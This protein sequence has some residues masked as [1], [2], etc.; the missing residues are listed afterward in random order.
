MRNN[1]SEMNKQVFAV[2]VL[3]RFVTEESFGS[4]GGMNVEYIAR[5]SVSRF[6]SSQLNSLAGQFISGFDLNMDLESSED[7]TTGGK[8]N[9]TDLNVSVSKSLF[10]DRLSVSVGNDFLLEGGQNAGGRSS[11]IPGNFSADY[12]LTEDGRYILR[13]YRR[14]ELQNLIDGY[15]V[16]TGLGFR[17]SLQ[18]NRFRYLFMSNA[19]RRER[20]RQ[21]MEQQRRET[22]ELQR[23]TDAQTTSNPAEGSNK[24]AVLVYPATV[25]SSNEK[26]RVLH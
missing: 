15:V 24:E 7:Y 9:R 21:M 12:R 4:G 8:V 13:G 23:K 6:L 20:F 11:G 18:Y 3:K 26:R 2:I 25:P 5:Q 14:N 17:Y 1:P 19:K 10:N 16:E 22:E